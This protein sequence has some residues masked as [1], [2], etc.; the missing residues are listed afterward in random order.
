MGKDESSDKN[1]AAISDTSETQITNDTAVM[2]NRL[3]DKSN[4]RNYRKRKSSENKTNL[5]D[6]EIIESDGEINRVNLEEIKK[7]KRYKNDENIDADSDFSQDDSSDDE[8]DKKN[9]DNINVLPENAV[10][11]EETESVS[12]LK[13]KQ[14]ID[15]V[16]KDD[17]NKVEEKPKIDIWKKRTVGVIFEEALKRYYERKAARGS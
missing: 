4:K 5:S 14:E 10:S 6:G 15:S 1:E 17:Q 12:D 9:D 7:A 8:V 16:V 13:S 2:D 11:K 3:I